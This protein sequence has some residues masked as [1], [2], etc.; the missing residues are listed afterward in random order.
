VAADLEPGYVLA[1]VHGGRP[2][3]SAGRV[4]F[5]GPRR[6]ALEDRSVTFAFALAAAPPTSA[7]A[8]GAWGLAAALLAL[9]AGLA[10]AGAHRRGRRPAGWPPVELACHAAFP[11]VVATLLAYSRARLLPVAPT[12]VWLGAAAAAVGLALWSAR[13]DADAGPGGSGHDEGAV[14]TRL[15]PSSEM[16]SLA[17]LGA[18]LPP[19]AAPLGPAAF[20]LGLAARRNAVPRL[21]RA[22]CAV[23]ASAAVAAA[24]ALA[25]LAS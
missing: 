4:L 2:A 5:S 8:P 17:A 21:A 13:T 7:A 16:L 11:G 9:A 20:G 18:L 19:V 1:G 24:A 12:P 15:I 3:A 6:S 23:A 25:R 10:L 22:A 14:V